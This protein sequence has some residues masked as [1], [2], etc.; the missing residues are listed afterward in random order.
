M[1]LFS[2]GTIAAAILSLSLSVAES[3]VVVVVELSSRAMPKSCDSSPESKGKWREG[4]LAW[5]IDVSIPGVNDLQGP[6]T[7]RL[8]APEMHAEEGPVI[9]VGAE[10]VARSF[11]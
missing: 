2:G 9:E 4:L 10:D 1:W 3:V 11:E 6:S 8:L 7:V 5:W